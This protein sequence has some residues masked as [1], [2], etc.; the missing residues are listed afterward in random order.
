MDSSTG[1]TL[2]AVERTF[3]V[4]DALDDAG[5]A[6]GVTDLADRI[7]LPTSTVHVHLQTLYDRNYVVK[8]GEKYTLS[9]GFLHRGGR[10]RERLPVYRQGREVVRDLARET[11][12]LIN[13]TVEQE[14]KGVIVFVA[15]GEDTAVD[16]HT[17]GKYSYLHQTAFGKAMLACFSD[18]KV[19]RIADR[20]GLD[21][22]TEHT[23]TNLETLFGDIKRIRERG[24]ATERQEG[25]NGVSCIGAAVTD[26]DGNPH[27]AVSATLPA[28]KLRDRSVE[29]ELSQQILNGTNV[30]ELKMENA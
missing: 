10:I 21:P 7:G 16:L 20:W 27:G 5:C 18:E 17:L 12:E 2:Q 8:Q 15:N 14:G 24:Y 6:L 13:L 9:L 11:G 23:I 22:V 25:G 30:I 19:E 28:N 4:V 29:E 3:D 1:R 26:P